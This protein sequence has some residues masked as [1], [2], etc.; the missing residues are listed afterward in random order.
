MS[1]LLRVGILIIFAATALLIGTYIYAS[2]SDPAL[3][4]RMQKENVSSMYTTIMMVGVFVMLLGAASPFWGMIKKSEKHDDPKVMEQQ[5]EYLQHSL[6]KDKG[7]TE[8]TKKII[9]R[10]IAYYK[11]I[12]AQ[13]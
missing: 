4:I 5:I 2:H 1:P 10:K 11:T 6:D 3:L 8:D 9:Q 13:P 12:I 7:L